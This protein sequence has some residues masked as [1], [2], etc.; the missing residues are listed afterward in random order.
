MPSTR[1]FLMVLVVAITTA[2]GGTPSTND[3]NPTD[4]PPTDTVVPRDSPPPTDVAMMTDAGPLVDVVDVVTADER[5]ASD[6]ADEPSVPP[7]DV[8]VLEGFDPR[9]CEY[10]ATSILRVRGSTMTPEMPRCTMQSDRS[11]RIVISASFAGAWDG[12]YSATCRGTT[13]EFCPGHLC[14]WTGLSIG[15]WEFHAHSQ[16]RPDV[17]IDVERP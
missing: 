10:L 13:C 17:I 2:C 14:F 12:G 9:L 8:A 1:A 5:V 11:A 3:V 16:I 15:M 4:V 6:V 7:S